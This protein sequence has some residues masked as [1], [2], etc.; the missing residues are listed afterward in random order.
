MEIPAGD[1]LCLCARSQVIGNATFPL[2]PPS[3]PGKGSHL[4]RDLV[5]T[6]L[7]I[8]SRWIGAN[9]VR[10]AMSAL[11]NSLSRRERARVRENA[12]QQMTPHKSSASLNYW[13]NLDPVLAHLPTAS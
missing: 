8:L 7:G 4:Y 3:P 9:G 10:T 2:T 1:V 13:K 5:R 11:D 12:S 6:K